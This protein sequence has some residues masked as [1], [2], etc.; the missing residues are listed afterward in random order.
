ME[1]L[2]RPRRA[3]SA[4]SPGPRWEDTQSP[5]GVVFQAPVEARGWCSSQSLPTLLPGCSASCPRTVL[6]QRGHVAKASLARQGRGTL[7]GKRVLGSWGC[8]LG[9]YRHTLWLVAEWEAVC[10]GESGF[11]VVWAGSDALR[12]ARAGDKEMQDLRGVSGEVV[13]A[14]ASLTASQHILCWA[15][16]P[17]CLQ[18]SE[19]PVSVLGDSVAS[20]AMSLKEQL[21]RPSVGAGAAWPRRSGGPS[22]ECGRRQRGVGPG[23]WAAQAV[24]EA[25]VCSLG[26]GAWALEQGTACVELP[27]MGVGRRSPGAPARCPHGVSVAFYLKCVRHPWP[28]QT[29]STSI[30]CETGTGGSGS[31]RCRYQQRTF[32]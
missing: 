24:S 28:L 23:R 10:G 6:G 16:P 31:R 2:S 30:P 21:E 7:V 3:P 18:G 27:H 26:S 29:T 5:S 12:E 8:A 4:S 20:G 1:A 25:A 15:V 11:W 19:L 32:S 13:L 14:T 9:Y 22:G 17:A